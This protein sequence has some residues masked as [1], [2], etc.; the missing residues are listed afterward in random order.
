[1]ETNLLLAILVVVIALIFDFSNGFN[2]SANIVATVIG[3]RALTPFQAIV[4]ASV[5]EFIGA[6]FLGTAVAK[7]I[8]R[9]IVDPNIIMLEKYGIVIIFATLISAASWNII[10]TALGFPVSASH[11]LLG[12]FVGASL[13]AGYIKTRDFSAALQIVQWPTILKIA[14]TL[15]AAPLIGLIVSFM[16]TKISYFLTRRAKPGITKVFRVLQVFS[17]IGFALSHGANDA[18]KTMGIITFS[19]IV[20]GVY[21]PIGD[22]FIPQWVIASCALFIALGV[23]SGGRSVIKTVGMNIF[24]I[25]HLNGFCAEYSGSIVIYVAS[26]LGLP[27]SSTH[28]ITGAVMGTGAAE[29]IKAVRW[30]VGYDIFFIWVSTIPASILLSSFIYF[31]IVAVLK[32]LN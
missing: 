26:A 11:A 21:R 2:D 27:V 29:R 5:F 17:S 28:I 10:C 12:G 24:K 20:L 31:A 8:G 9:G 23:A 1:M 13:T 15:I 18:Q 4:I 30:G 7:T 22:A 16:L 32:L 19:L 14:I 3:T 6:Y 25:K